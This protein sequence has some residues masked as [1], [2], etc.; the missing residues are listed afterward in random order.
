MATQ[1]YS[2]IGQ[3]D[4]ELSKPC[5]WSEDFI[6]IIRQTNRKLAYDAIP[7]P[8]LLLLF[9]NLFPKLPLLTLFPLLPLL[10][11]LSFHPPTLYLPNNIS[12]TNNNSNSNTIIIYF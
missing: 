12:N 5:K 11:S 2:F 4:E 3:A 6:Q 7:T 1:Y 8:C 9:S 10:H